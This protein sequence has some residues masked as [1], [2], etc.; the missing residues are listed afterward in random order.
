MYFKARN[1]TYK[2]VPQIPNRYLNGEVGGMTVY[3][4]TSYDG[5]KSTAFK[6]VSQA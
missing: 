6:P 3:Y 2:R 5:S 4:T 1:G